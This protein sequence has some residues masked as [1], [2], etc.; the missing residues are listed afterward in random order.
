VG[1]GLRMYLTKRILVRAEY[2]SYLTFT[3][4]EVNEELDEWKAGFAF[5]F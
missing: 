2:S 5:F 4:R 1:L 3:S